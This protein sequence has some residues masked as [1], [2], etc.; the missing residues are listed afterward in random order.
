MN[1]FA[2]TIKGRSYLVATEQSANAVR[3]QLAE[4][5][6]E[7]NVAESGIPFGAGGVTFHALRGVIDLELERELREAM[8]AMLRPIPRKVYKAE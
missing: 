5:E 8:H 2:V 3:R 1:V 4:A 6:V 7:A